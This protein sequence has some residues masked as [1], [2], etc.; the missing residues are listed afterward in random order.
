MAWFILFS[1]LLEQKWKRWSTFT[2][3]EPVFRIIAFLT[4]NTIILVWWFCWS[5]VKRLNWTVRSYY[6]RWKKKIQVCTSLS[7]EYYISLWFLFLYLYIV[8]S[9]QLINRRLLNDLCATNSMCRHNFNL[10]VVASFLL[11]IPIDVNTLDVTICTLILLFDNS[12]HLIF[13]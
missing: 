10:L 5:T 9:G 7:A 4:I 13:W 1:L 11:L 8:L 12:L 6:Y 3:F 2:L